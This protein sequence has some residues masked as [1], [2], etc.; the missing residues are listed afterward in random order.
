MTSDWLGEMF[1]GD[2]TDMCGKISIEDGTSQALSEQATQSLK[3]IHG[4]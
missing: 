1:E 2:V 3:R 4:E